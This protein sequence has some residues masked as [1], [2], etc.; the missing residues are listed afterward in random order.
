[1]RGVRITRLGLGAISNGRTSSG[2]F[3]S[4]L[5]VLQ[6]VFDVCA[7]RNR[8]A[9][10]GSQTSLVFSNTAQS[11]EVVNV[12]VDFQ[13]NRA[14]SLQFKGGLQCLQC[15]LQGAAVSNG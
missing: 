1:M 10:E 4:G 15:S 2:I 13:D 11:D 7:V 14:C 5:Q 6:C 12:N 8:G 3:S 9:G